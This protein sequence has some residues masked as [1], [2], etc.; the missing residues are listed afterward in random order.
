MNGEKF[1]VF[2]TYTEMRDL[3]FLISMNN[4]ELLAILIQIAY[5]HL[6]YKAIC[7]VKIVV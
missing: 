6:F 4:G 3:W 1:N 5:K 2:G 7:V